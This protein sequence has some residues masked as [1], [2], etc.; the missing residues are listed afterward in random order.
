MTRNNYLCLA[1]SN[2]LPVWICFPVYI[3]RRIC[4]H[5]S[6]LDLRYL[7]L[8]IKGKYI[9]IKIRFL[10]LGGE[11]QYISNPY[12][13]IFFIVLGTK[14]TLP[15]TGKKIIILFC[16]LGYICISIV[17]YAWRHNRVKIIF[18]GKFSDNFNAKSY[19]FT[20]VYFKL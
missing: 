18:P 5:V 20:P 17:G 2:L 10:P 8:S 16:H 11:I 6:V 1:V 7:K 4:C 19:Y 9:S 15:F 14:Y 12:W 13:L 3:S